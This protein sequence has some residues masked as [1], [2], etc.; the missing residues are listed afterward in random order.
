LRYWRGIGLWSN[1]ESLNKN[2]KSESTGS[3]T[4]C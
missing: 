2:Q 4:R 1:F 3:H